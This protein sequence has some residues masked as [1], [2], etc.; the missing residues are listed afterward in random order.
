MDNRFKI[1]PEQTLRLR[2]LRTQLSEALKLS[3]QKDF[4]YSVAEYPEPR[5]CAECNF[6]CTGNCVGNCNG[7]CK[8]HCASPACSN[9]CAEQGGTCSFSLSN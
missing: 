1:H 8:A 6:G 2:E 3:N 9:Q 4:E 5:I 7:T